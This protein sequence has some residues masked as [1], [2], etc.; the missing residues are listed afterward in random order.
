M[1]DISVG[2][3]DSNLIIPVP[4]L[5]K[6]MTLSASYSHVIAKSAVGS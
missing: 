2:T 3:E 5:E 4:H 6:G 1:L